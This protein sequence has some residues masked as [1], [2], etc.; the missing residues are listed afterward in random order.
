MRLSWS[1]LLPSALCTAAFFAFVVGAGLKAQLLP[2]RTGVQTMMGQKVPALTRINTAGGMIFVEGEYWT[3]TS[4][5]P[6]EPGEAVEIT[7]RDGLNLRVKP[8]I[9]ET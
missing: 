1:V 3:A 2:A 7:G 4:E 9:L 6:V 5:T 8:L